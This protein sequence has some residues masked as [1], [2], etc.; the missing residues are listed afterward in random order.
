MSARKRGGDDSDATTAA[1][2]ASGPEDAPDRPA[3]DPDATVVSRP[4][5]HSGDANRRPGYAPEATAASLPTAHTGDAH[6]QPGHAPEATAASLPTAHTGDAHRQPAHAPDATAPSLPTAHTGDAHRQPA[7]APDATAPSLPTTHTGNANRRPA[8][9]TDAA[10]GTRPTPHPGDATGGRSAHDR[11]DPRPATGDPVRSGKSRVARRPE[12][13]TQERPARLPGAGA[14]KPSRGLRASSR[15]GR[16]VPAFSGGRAA[17]ALAGEDGG[18]W[19]AMPRA[20][21]GEGVHFML[22]VRDDTMAG[23]A[24]RSGDLVVVRR[25]PSAEAGDIVAAMVE[26]ETVVRIVQAGDDAVVL[27]RVVAVLRQL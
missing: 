23:A 17:P 3:H 6:R 2:S 5:W 24:V 15:R 26:G 11:A 25:Q 8:H 9:H 22:R 14:K 12:G 19:L 21:V 1:R 27:G 16:A 13:T 10:E 20:V 7:H 18:E 4:T